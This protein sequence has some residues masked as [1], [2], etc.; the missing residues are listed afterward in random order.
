MPALLALGP[1]T[2]RQVLPAGGCLTERQQEALE[3]WA[4]SGHIKKENR[5]WQ[6]EQNL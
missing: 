1:G 5:V 6:M 2:C 4:A 3:A